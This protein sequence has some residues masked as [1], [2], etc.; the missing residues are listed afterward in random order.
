[1]A[2]ARWSTVT[3]RPVRARI[4]LLAVRCSQGGIAVESRVRGFGFPGSPGS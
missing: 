2:Q 4:A 3:W 1:M